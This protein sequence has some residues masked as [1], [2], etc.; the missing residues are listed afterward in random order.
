VQE[1]WETVRRELAG[2]RGRVRWLAFDAV[3][4]LIAPQPSVAEAYWSIGRQFGSQLAL[5][6]VGRRFSKVFRETE[7]NDCA[8][9]SGLA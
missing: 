5:E 9:E 4:T 2:L 1:E 3:G 8:P 6:E 7:Q